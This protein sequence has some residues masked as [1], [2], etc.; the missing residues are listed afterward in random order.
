M[1]DERRRDAVAKP[2]FVIE[3]VNA[4]VA[5]AA[6]EAA[7]AATYHGLAVRAYPRGW[8]E[9]YE[10]AV[11]SGI[12]AVPAAFLLLYF[13]WMLVVGVLGRRWGL[14]WRSSLAFGLAAGACLGW[15]QS[16]VSL[17]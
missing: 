10:L 16:V 5:F 3:T 1:A 6:C 12:L 9:R 13:V 8:G 14:R 2:D 11:Y 4:L 17:V 7:Y 15:L